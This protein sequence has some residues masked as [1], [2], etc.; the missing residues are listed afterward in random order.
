LFKITIYLG[1]KSFNEKPKS[2]KTKTLMSQAYKGKILSAKTKLKLSI[3]RSGENN[4]MFGQIH[5][6]ETKALMSIIYTGKKF[7]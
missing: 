1:N 7:C 2:D 4:V 3:A 6:I 5:S